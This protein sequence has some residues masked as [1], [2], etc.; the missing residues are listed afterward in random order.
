MAAT[1]FHAMHMRLEAMEKKWRS[2][3]N[4]AVLSA[5]TAALQAAQQRA[6]V[7]TGRLR[8]G[9]RMELSRNDGMEGKVRSDAPYS[10]YVE[11]G[12]GS[13][14]AGGN[15]SPAVR[16]APPQ[17]FLRPAFDVGRQRALE[18]LKEDRT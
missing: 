15:G 1:G 16:G 14:A 8:R 3:A 6:P 7:D 17:P 9:I 12:T 10:L 5:T 4:A 11:M 2:K 13:R 18:V